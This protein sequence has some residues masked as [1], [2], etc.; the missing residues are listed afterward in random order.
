[1]L[2]SEIPKWRQRTTNDVL[3]GQQFILCVSVPSTTKSE[4]ED[5]QYTLQLLT[6]N[7]L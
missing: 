2:E 7:S 4:A 3:C 1:M 6:R 5:S